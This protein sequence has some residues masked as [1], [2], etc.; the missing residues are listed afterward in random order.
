M[1]TA[2]C[3]FCSPFEPVL[4]N[5]LALARY[6]DFPVSEGHMLLIPRRHEAR[7]FDLTR[8]EKQALWSLLD[9]AQALLQRQKNPDGF[10]IGIN[11]G[12]AAGQSVMHVHLHLIPRYNGDVADPRGGVRGV[13]PAKQ[14]YHDLLNRK[15]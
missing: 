14:K 11:C 6:D 12:S 13:I 3:L 2:A 1:T 5:E 4:S 15:T 9:E 7:Y 10:N 8:E